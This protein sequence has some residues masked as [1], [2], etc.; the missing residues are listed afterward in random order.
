MPSTAAVAVAGLALMRMRELLP[1]D[2]AY[3]TVH[4]FLAVCP[5]G[6]AYLGG[7]VWTLRVDKSRTKN[8]IRVELISADEDRQSDRIASIFFGALI[9]ERFS[10]TEVKDFPWTVVKN[11]D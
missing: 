3:K 2:G 11:N 9:G 10:W 1:Q 8:S 6:V 4:K 5:S 7:G